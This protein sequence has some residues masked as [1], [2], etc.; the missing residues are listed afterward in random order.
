MGLAAPPP[1]SQDILAHAQLW[2]HQLPQG[3]LFPLLEHE[4]F[5]DL[6]TG[7]TGIHWPVPGAFCAR[8]KQQNFQSKAGVSVAWL[9]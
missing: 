9:C 7:Q 8:Y 5:S 1:T 4:L 6:F 2:D 3:R